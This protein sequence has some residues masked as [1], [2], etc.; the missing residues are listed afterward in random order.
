MADRPSTDGIERFPLQY[1]APILLLLLW[2]VWP[3]VSGARTLYQR[4][5]LN[6]HL[7]MK[8]AETEALRQGYLPLIDPHRAGGQ[9]LLGNPN[10]LALYPDTLLYLAAPLFWALN[11]HF[12][13]HFLLAPFAFSWLARELGLGRAG[14]WAAGVFYALSG[15]YLSLFVFYNLIVSAT[16]A[17]AFAAAC[18]RL[19][20]GRRPG[21]LAIA[22]AILWAMLLL[23]GDPLGSVIALG[24]ALAA[25][26]LREGPKIRVFGAVVAA[27]ACGTLL[28]APQ[29]VEFLRV[30]GTSYRGT[31]GYSG[32]A[33]TAESWD[34]RQA[35]DWLLPF[36]FGRPDL[37]GSGGFWGHRFYTDLPPYLL[38]L[39]PGLLALALLTASLFARGRVTRWAQT[40]LLLGLFLALGRF[41][42]LATWIFERTGGLLRFPVRLWIL[43]AI[44]GSVLTGIGFEK[45][46]AGK[47]TKATRAF[48]L[49]LAGMA[50]LFA[51]GWLVL[52]SPAGPAEAFLRR[53]TPRVFGAA[54]IAGVRERWAGL[55]A[56]SLGTLA[57]LSTGALLAR[58]RPA[59]GGSCLLVAHA[60]A[61][62]VFLSPLL[63][64][65]AVGAYS[66]P[67]P[68]L[69]MV[70]I[71]SLVVHG[72]SEGLFAKP[73][74]ADQGLPDRR[75][76]WF[77]RRAF[78]ELYPF[79]GALWGRS[80]ELNVSS[81][82][83]D[84]F[85]STAA[86]DAARLAT[87]G[88]RVRLLA[89]WGVDR[90]LL[91]RPID[92]EAADRVRLLGRLP[93]FGGSLY[94]YEIPGATPQVYLAKRVLRA[95]DPL[96]ALRLLKDPSFDP[97]TGAV[98]PG[99]GPPAEGSGGEV[100]LLERGPENLSAEVTAG[101]AGL[102]V[103]QRAFQ[104]IYR[105]T[106]DGVP[107]TLRI[108]NLHRFG[109]DVPAGR[110]RVD[111]WVDRRP[112]RVSLLV[113]FLGLCGLAV[114]AR[115]PGPVVEPV[116]AG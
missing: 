54:D 77:E 98:V 3:L 92:P 56:G 14:S 18:L 99:S 76:F 6:T 10:A 109:V 106:V 1:I 26:T 107:A 25:M 39:Y 44:G 111:L 63:A 100:H 36:A 55:C 21:L 68:A 58:R 74:R 15:H 17:P 94:V 62:I 22:V 49:A 69:D 20:A 57:V 115:R 52:S 101:S 73:G 37:L 95:P 103:V 85:L 29:I 82:G 7:G 30:L 71:S 59:E 43:V 67:S 90:L 108:A 45:V 112:L 104:P 31:Y 114:L 83:M 61:Q 5:V 23:S 50:L 12:W 81:E 80:Y 84:S 28:A 93:G 96:G 13:I 41:N 72:A 53:M 75:G 91:D 87:D 51:S 24:L 116:R 38:S 32:S 48:W 47:E 35:I 8:W 113:S 64:S 86:R 33:L 105:A 46:V 97:L 110:H 60:A 88:E 11:A 66:A 78:H 27:V 34:P 70:P 9:P 16:L 65:D 4:D 19:A 2:S 79:A 42:P 102:L 89:S 40:V